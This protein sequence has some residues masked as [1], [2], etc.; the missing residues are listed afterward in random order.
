MKDLHRLKVKDWKKIF[1]ANGE[2]K[3]ARVAILIS[4][5][6]DVRTKATKRDKEGH[7]IILKRIIHQEDITL[8]NICTQH[9]TIQIYKGNLG[10]LQKRNKQQHTHGRGF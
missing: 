1:Q 5:Q 8:V 10:G 6:I 7:F 3:I 9:R 4:D 2:G